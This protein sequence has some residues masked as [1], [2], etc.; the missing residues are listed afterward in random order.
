M[1][2]K[3]KQEVNMKKIT[4][5]LLSHKVLIICLFFLLFFNTFALSS[6]FLEYSKY[7]NHAELNIMEGRFKEALLLYDSAFVLFQQ[8]L[9]KDIHNAIICSEKIKNEQL[10]KKYLDL[11]IETKSLHPSYY[12]KEGLNKYLSKEK[13]QEI[14]KKFSDKAKNEA[15]IFIQK[16]SKQDQAIRTQ[17]NYTV[18]R[19]LIAEVDE[20]TFKEYQ[21]YFGNSFPGEDLVINFPC[22]QREDFILFWHWSQIGYDG[23]LLE[24]L[25]EEL[26]FVNVSFAYLNEQRK[27]TQFYKSKYALVAQ[28]STK[29]VITPIHRSQWEIAEIDKNRAKI[30]LDSYDEYVKKV[31]FFKKNKEFC[32][33]T[34]YYLIIFK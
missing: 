15:Y 20:F 12:T 31:D 26:K 27:G 28:T 19:H 10:L 21:N 22:A 8:P 11:M 4:N 34:S 3:K 23:M 16:L 9:A 1:D 29:R 5:K 24:E 14:K 6:K 32:Y 30:G 33:E 2:V 17:K 25:V 13:K 7:T 18:N